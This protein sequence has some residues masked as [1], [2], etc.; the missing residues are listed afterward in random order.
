MGNDAWY[1]QVA[2]SRP[3]KNQPWYHIL[4][5][6]ED[7]ETYVAERNLIED[8]SCEPVNHPMLGEFFVD[9]NHGLYH[10]GKQT[11]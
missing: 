10:S 11:N 3:P 9:F 2:Q 4:V 7:H 6:D 5:H 1:D 8:E